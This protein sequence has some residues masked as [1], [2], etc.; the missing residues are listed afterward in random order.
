[1]DN[2]N[3]GD[4]VCIT[5]LAVENDSVFA[6][7]YGLVGRLEHISNFGDPYPYYVHFDK[8]IPSYESTAAC[9]KPCIPFKREELELAYTPPEIK[10]GCL[11]IFGLAG[12]TV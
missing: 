12:V 6:K 7:L 10:V 8:R 1:M 11:D 4:Y 2:L 5:Q 9:G 3:V